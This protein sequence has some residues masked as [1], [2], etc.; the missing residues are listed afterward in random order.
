MKSIF[1]KLGG[2]YRQEGDYLLPNMEAPESPSIGV[3]VSSGI[4]TWWNIT[5]HSIRLCFLTVCSISA[6]N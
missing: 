6:T 3:W 1:K 2:T 5:M 4:S